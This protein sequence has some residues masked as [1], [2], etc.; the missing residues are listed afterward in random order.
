MVFNENCSLERML[1]KLTFELA[2][3]HQGKEKNVENVLA[4]ETTFQMLK[5]Q[6]QS[7]ALCKQNF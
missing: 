4:F 2:F 1:S 5:I 7:L 6:M 3:A